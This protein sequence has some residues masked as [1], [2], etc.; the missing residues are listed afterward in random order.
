VEA[1]VDQAL[2]DVIHRHAEFGKGAGVEDAFMRHPALV[3]HEQD[4][5]FAFQP[6]GDVIG[7][8]DRHAGCLRQPF[9]AHHQAIGPRDQQDRGDP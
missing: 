9:A 4:R 2:G 8:E 5:E 3:A 7:V 1:V 6:T